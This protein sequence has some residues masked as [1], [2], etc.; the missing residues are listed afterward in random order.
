MNMRAT[1]RENITQHEYPDTDTAEQLSRIRTNSIRTIWVPH[2]GCES[3]FWRVVGIVLW[4]CQDPFEK[5]ALT[6]HSSSDDHP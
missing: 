5:S 3:E 4:E 1:E 2:V 6:A